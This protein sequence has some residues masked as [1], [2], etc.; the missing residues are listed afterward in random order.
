MTSPLPSVDPPGRLH[1]GLEYFGRGRVFSY[2]HQIETVRSFGADRVLEIGVGAGMA[3]S[4]LR[5]MGFRVTTVDVQPELNPDIVASVT[6]LPVDSE[7]YDV[8]VCC[9]VLEH[10]PFEQFIPALRE[11]RR[12]T[13]LGA[14]ISLPDVTRRWFVAAK[15]P[16]C[17]PL[18]IEWTLPGSGRKVI[19][20]SRLID[21]GHHW[22]IGYKGFSRATVSRAMASA[23]W[24]VA[25][26]WH[27][28]EMP[29]HHFFK[30][31]R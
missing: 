14:V 23:G 24:T 22:E 1:Y 21:A 5:A 31:T 29:W 19:P 4:A 13:T 18:R 30:L 8:A 7:E 16:K 15:L 6:A 2:A 20:L 9:Q 26:N 3:A 17:A 25:A 11:L 10:L 12:V 28:P 27:V